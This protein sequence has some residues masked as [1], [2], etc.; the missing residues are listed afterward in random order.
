[1]V[2]SSWRNVS[3]YLLLALATLFWAGNA[4][5]A[6]ALHDFLPP[7]TM[8]FGRWVLASVILLPFVL[9]PMYRQRALLRASWGRLVLLSALGV[10]GG[11]T[12]TYVA[13]QT[14]TAT[15]SVLISSVSPLL[16]VFL[17]W[18]LFSV[19]LARKQQA[20]IVLSLI[21]MAVIVSRGDASVFSRLDF[22]RGDFILIGSSFLWALYTVFLRWRPAGIGAPAF[23]G[24]TVMIGAVL[25]LPFYVAETMSGRNA[26]WNVATG[27]GLAYIAIFPSVLAY[28]FWNRGVHQ[29]GANRAALFLYLV[30]VFG[31]ALAVTFLGEWLHLF[32]LIGA[33]LIFAGIYLGTF[34]PV[35]E[36]RK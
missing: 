14:T 5:V 7:V 32:H 3:P 19:K 20:G 28:L 11:N 27:A 35:A 26:V 16:I 21:G 15:N 30:P 18:V 23:L 24:S 17:G 22:D 13:L 9:R 29:V 36:Y 25:L 33:A 10:S 4:V 31:I 8:A 12:L 6:R 34:H 1:M 2:S